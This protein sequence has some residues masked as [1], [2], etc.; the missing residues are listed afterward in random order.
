MGSLQFCTCASAEYLPFVRVLARSIGRHH[1]GRRLKVLLCYDLEHRLDVADEPFD[2]YWNDVLGLDEPELHRQYLM[3]GANFMAAAKPHFL[4]HLVRSTGEPTLYVDAD[5]AVYANLDDLGALIERSGTL[6]SPHL[7]APLPDDGLQPDD[8]TILSAG[9]YNA[10]LLGV[11]AGGQGAL[12]LL[13]AK[14]RRECIT[15]PQQMRVNEQR[16]L[17]LVPA[18]ASATVLKDPGVNAAYWNLHERPLEVRD[19]VIH[20]G[21]VPLR[22]F[23]F[24][25]YRFETPDVLSVYGGGPRARITLADQP[26]LRA[27]AEAF[28]AEVIAEGWRPVSPGTVFDELPGGIPVDVALREAYRRSVIAAEQAGE[29]VPPDGYDPGS[30]DAFLA[31]ARE[32]YV[33]SGA[34][35]PSWARSAPA[36][37]APAPPVADNELGDALRSLAAATSAAVAQLDERLRHLEG[38]L[39]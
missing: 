21:E 9:V 18:V 11:G 26:L 37:S 19:G 38:R 5:V 1:P 2:A 22:A 29:A 31:W 13:N 20:A 8:T 4:Q 3:H 28:R 39:A 25:G 6:L 30:R 23:H 10:G 24:S 33:R 34:A 27:L 35:I 15:A 12:E 17:D 16:W 7:L 36:E 14:L 32:L